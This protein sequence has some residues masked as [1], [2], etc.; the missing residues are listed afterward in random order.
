MTKVLVADDHPVVREGLATILKDEPE[1]ETVDEA[2]DGLEVMQ[3][4][5]NKPYDVLVLDL[6]MPHMDGLETINKIKTEF[7]KLAILV[8]STNPEEFFG[9]RTLKL[10]ASGYLSKECAPEELVSAV[11]LVKD[12]Q[13]Y[14]SQR[15]AQLL[16]KSYTGQLQGPGGIDLS[17]REY[18]VMTMIAKGKSVK[19]IAVE[20]SLSAKTVSAHRTHIL[21]KLHLENNAQIVSLAFQNKLPH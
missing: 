16:A 18:Q 15:L 1:F 3:K 6:S 8:L 21:R 19:Q 10:G 13:I 11:R 4:I 20:L 7:P 14:L 5:R 12:G 2:S 17:D 9:M